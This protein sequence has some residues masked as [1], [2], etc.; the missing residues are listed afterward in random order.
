M[1]N[2][3]APRL[4][5]PGLTASEVEESRRLHGSNGLTPP[6]RDPWWKQFLSKFEDPVIRILM[7]AAVIQIA[8]GAY[9]GE[10]I[11]GLAIVVAILLATTLAFIN[12]YKANAE[13]DILNRV[14]EEVPI[15]VIREARFQTVPRK[16]LVVGDIVLIETG[17]EAPIDGHVLEAVALVVNES[18]LTG[19]SN[20]V[21]KF[22]TEQVAAHETGKEHAYP[23][24]K[25]L[26][27]CMVADGHG[28]VRATAVGDGT[29]IGKTARAAAEET[30][31]TTP[32]NQQLERLSKLIGVVGLGIAALTFLALIFRGAATGSLGL[33]GGQWV[34]AGMM[35]GSIMIALVRVWLPI[36]FDA[37]EFLGIKLEPPGWLENE[38]LIG[39]LV[40][41][42]VGAVVFGIALGVGSIAGW[43]PENSSQWL[44]RTAA[45]ALLNYFM[46]AVVIIVVAVPE[47]LAMSVTLSLAYSMRK[48]TAQNNL[49][50]KMHACE[51]IG[52]ATVICSDKTGTLTQNEMRVLDIQLP[53]LSSS[54]SESLVYE[55]IAANSTAQLTIEEGVARPLG[56]PT[57]GALLLWLNERNL[58]YLALRANFAVGRQLPFSTERKYM[59]TAGTSP[60]GSQRLYVKGA[61]EVILAASQTML[62]ANGPQPLSDAEKLSITEAL[63]SFQQRGMRTL[64]F[65]TKPITSPEADIE[66][67]VNGLTWVGFV[68]IADPVRPEVPHSIVA[69][70]SAGIGIKIVTGDTAD[71]AREIGRQIGLLTVDEDPDTVLTGAEF[72]AMSDEQAAKAVQTMK[73]LARA[74]PMDKMRLVKLLKDQGHVVAVTG[75]GTNDAPALNHA[76]VGLAMGKSGTSVAKEAADIILLDDSF[77]SIVNAVMWGRSLYL[78]IQRFILFQ[79][80]INVAALGVALIGPFVGVD[81]PLT[82]M[83]MLWVNLI[84]DT[85]AA[86]ALATEPPSESVLKK[87]PRNSKAFIITGEMARLIFGVGGIFLVMLVAMLTFMPSGV[88]EHGGLDDKRPL[89][90]FF[91]IFVLLQFW[92]LFNARCLGTSRTA[93]AGLTANPY[94]LMIA[95]AILL[96]QI[97]LVQIGGEVF[98]T[99][100][101]TALEWLAIIAGT[102]PVLLIGEALRWR[103]RNRVL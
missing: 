99:V 92:N 96:G 91:S 90:I 49:V 61:P 65:A 31:E 46:I 37:L 25:L 60:D 51:T 33:L 18:R 68:A 69:C 81:F 87:P 43:L 63:R 26:R 24:D 5:H 35:I 95:A 1:S 32:L 66:P 30:G 53:A 29:E 85:F 86:L 62:G 45:E 41:L 14:N 2:V 12:E 71:T 76:D 16:D 78:N 84:M 75:D 101:L 22:A 94:F 3:A 56:N 67:Q 47:G 50:R 73:V 15:K 7:V 59:A 48:M 83:Q 4:P 36:F 17:E 9:K 72:N 57:E 28:T 11:E 8:V 100:P 93:L 89:T 44:P 38:G 13:F 42:G 102:S 80:T 97:A 58:D 98:R 40:T 23:P 64:G 6:E 77:S 82:V 88:G 39:W 20:P 79:L 70:Q 55:G 27:G 52:A 103:S 10:Y 19:E 21:E 54:T 34:F 74:R